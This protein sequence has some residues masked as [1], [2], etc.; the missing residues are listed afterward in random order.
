[1]EREV[2]AVE[3]EVQ[4]AAAVGEVAAGDAGLDQRTKQVQARVHAH[5][6][7]AAFPVQRQRDGSARRQPWRVGGELVQ[8]LACLAVAASVED[9]PSASVGE[10]Q[11]ARVARLAA[12]DRV[13][14]RAGQHQAGLVVAQHLRRA[15]AQIGVAIEQFGHGG[16]PRQLAKRTSTASASTKSPCSADTFSMVPA[17]GAFK[18]SSIF[19]AS[20][21]SSSWPSATLSPG[22]AFTSTMRPGMGAMTWLPPLLSLDF[23]A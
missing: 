18:A 1:V 13:A 21:T 11:R 2:E 15:F 16:F 19:I 8:D 7:V 23:H 4:P 3:V 17:R 22:L 20:I 10:A 5:V 14:D 6:A 12:A 9:G